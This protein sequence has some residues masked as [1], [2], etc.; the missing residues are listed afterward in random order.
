MRPFGSIG[1]PLPPP[2]GGRL[3]GGAPVPPVDV[4]TDIKPG[5]EEVTSI[6]MQ[7]PFPTLIPPPK[8]ITQHTTPAYVLPLG[9][10][11]NPV[12]PWGTSPQTPSIGENIEGPGESVDVEVRH[13]PGGAVDG[14]ARKNSGRENKGKK[15]KRK[16]KALR[17]PA[18]PDGKLE[19]VEFGEENEEET[20]SDQ[21]E[22]QPAFIPPS[23]SLPE[24]SLPAQVSPP[25]VIHPPSIAPTEPTIIDQE[26]LLR[27][28]GPP[29]FN[30]PLPP[31]IAPSAH[32][33]PGATDFG[34]GGIAWQGTL[35]RR[36]LPEP[37]SEKPAGGLNFV[38]RPHEEKETKAGASDRT[39]MPFKEV[40]GR[41]LGSWKVAIVPS[42]YK[43]MSGQGEST[44]LVSQ[45]L[46]TGMNSNGGQ[47]QKNKTRHRHLP[48]S[49]R[50]HRPN[51]GKA[52]IIDA[53]NRTEIEQLIHNEKFNRLINSLFSNNT[54]SRFTVAPIKNFSTPK[55]KAPGPF[56]T[57]F[58]SMPILVESSTTIILPISKKCGQPPDFI[59]C[60]PYEQANSR[61]LNCCQR[62]NMPAGCLE[63]CRYDITQKEIK[64]AFDA[65]KCG[66]LNVAP[67][68]DCA[69]GGNNNLECCRHRGVS[70]KSGPQCEVFCN[71]A[72]GFGALG[73]QHL[74]CQNVIGDLLQCHHSGLRP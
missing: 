5:V 58:T 59:P 14:Y 41:G 50:P 28:E 74:A 34:Q 24:P 39:T 40:S 21:T 61:L 51:S 68:L 49:G 25:P 4:D 64:K 11:T 27:T 52:H 30:G 7:T 3:G 12:I 71:P 17:P 56:L 36:D 66:L 23:G 32:I 19:L 48:D 20:T 44:S 42:G 16:N 54:I 2:R 35:W 65:G 63:L 38:I 72:G 47:N 62:K 73:L 29:I 6:P 37:T 67:F 43:S 18:F 9:F 45:N 13:L 55:A 1:M 22:V 60:L 69:S 57:T 26:E 8:Q 31:A 46:A 53:R 70:Q 33:P 15:K 10:T